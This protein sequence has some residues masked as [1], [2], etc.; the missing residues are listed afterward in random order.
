[1]RRPRMTKITAHRI[2]VAADYLARVLENDPGDPNDAK[3][4][5]RCRK[6]A[7]DFRRLEMWACETVSWLNHK[8]QQRKG[9]A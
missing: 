7:A 9:Q 5:A 2:S 8:A 4:A 6:E 3:H 1:M